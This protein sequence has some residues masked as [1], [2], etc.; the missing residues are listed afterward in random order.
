MGCPADDYVV[1][2]SQSPPGCTSP[3]AVLT[4]AVDMG[5]GPDPPTFYCCPCE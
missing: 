1:A 5:D 3:F 2:A 4:D